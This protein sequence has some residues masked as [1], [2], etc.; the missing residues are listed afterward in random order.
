MVKPL[1]IGVVA[2]GTRIDPELADRVAA[3]ASDSFLD[4]APALVFHPQC[5]LSNGP[6]AGDDDTRAAAL[7]EFANDAGFDAVWFASG[8]P[9]VHR[10][11]EAAL[12]QLGEAA[13]AKVYL[14][15]GG[16][17]VLLAGLFARGLGEVAHGPMPADMA[18]EGGHLAVRRA[19]AWL[20]ERAPESRDVGTLF[21]GPALAFNINVLSSIL[22]TALEPD[23]TGAALLL[24]ETQDYLYRIDRSL[25]HL[26]S[27]PRIRKA[28][29]IKL[30]RVSEAPENDRPFGADEEEIVRYWCG[31]SGIAYLGRCD[32]G[33]D[34]D[35][36]VVPFGWR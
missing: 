11:A 29:G 33:Q 23:V 31:R 12:A 22:G 6:L 35:N 34:A 27:S 18:R 2:P 25:F 20:I 5:F 7:A 15:A 21:D 10:M 26:T 30:G 24:E 1:R 32:I 28:R 9:G 17:G 16:A 8:G 13:R 19:L 3:F 36:K 4:Q 14:G